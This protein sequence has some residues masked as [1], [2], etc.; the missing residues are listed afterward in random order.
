MQ[1]S[2]RLTKPL[3][4]TGTK[5]ILCFKVNIH[6]V[7]MFRTAISLSEVLYSTFKYTLIFFSGYIDSN[8]FTYSFRVAHLA[9]HPAVRAY[10]T[11]DGVI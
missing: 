11:L 4:S 3:G 10:Y 8:I 6:I 9:K 1:E 5:F 2:A 7:L